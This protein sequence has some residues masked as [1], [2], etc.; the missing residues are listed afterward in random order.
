[1]VVDILYAYSSK[2]ASLR[3][4]LDWQ[5]VHHIDLREG[6]NTTN[7]KMLTTPKEYPAFYCGLFTPFYNLLSTLTKESLQSLT[8]AFFV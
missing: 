5:V 2:V 8:K 7:S 4:A 1:V 6:L 3:P